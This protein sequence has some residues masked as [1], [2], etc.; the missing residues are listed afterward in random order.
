MRVPP[1]TGLVAVLLLL[2]AMGVHADPAAVRQQFTVAY[3]IARAGT[4][5]VTPDSTELREYVLYPY[6]EAARLRR[7]LTANGAIAAFLGQHRDEP[8]ARALRREWLDALGTRRD[9]P[10]YLANYVPDAEDPATL[11]CHALAARI[12]LGR[13]RDVEHDA[14][15]Q[16][17]VDDSAPDACEPAFAW[18]R[19]RGLLTP[20]VIEQRAR[21]ALAA[22]HTTLARFL[23][24][25]LPAGQAAP[26]LLRADLLDRPQPTFDRLLETPDLKVEPDAVLDAWSR[27]VRRDPEAG[28][29]R[30]DR[31]LRSRGLDDATA[32]PYAAALGVGIALSRGAGALD[33]FARVRA[34]DF[35]ERAHEWHVRAA[36]WA[37]DWRR[38][39][40]AIEAMPTALASQNRWRYWAGRAAEKTRRHRE[41]ARVVR[42]RHPDRQLVCRTRLRASRPRVRTV[43]AA[44]PVRPG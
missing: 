4:P 36:L 15:E 37:G 28:I 14:L 17:L 10:T 6:L 43:V 27:W 29:A 12:A 32:S 34:E 26:L 3:L 42:A 8:V 16:W 35:D 24:R 7:D 18:L 25:D 33:Y 20:A 9:W 13:E 11:R 40:A 21:L 22:N 38:V 44:D 41:G 5:A 23:A 1:R 2:A 19:S 39:T 30:Y 31:L